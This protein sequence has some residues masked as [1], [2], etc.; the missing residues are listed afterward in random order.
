[1]ATPISPEKPIEKAQEATKAATTSAPR[2]RYRTLLFQ[3][4]LIAMTSAF[5]FLMVLA[6]STPFFPI[7]L[8][9]TR[10]IQLIS[11]P[12]FA[13]LMS[14]I[15]W[16]GYPPQSFIIPAFL[17]A[18]MW[19][20]GLRWEAVASL[21]AAISSS[22]IDVLVK[23][24]IRRP[25]PAADLVHVFRIL[26]SYSFPSGHVMFYVVFF[27][28]L[29]FL[30]FALLKPSPV[31]SVLLLFFAFMILTIGVSRIYLGQHWASDVL[32][33][34]LLGSLTLVANIAFYRWGKARFFVA[35][36]QP[37]NS[38]EAGA[39]HDSKQASR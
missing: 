9:I 12:A 36:T 15:S 18:L 39:R 10:G 29:F 21:V 32:G 4:T 16:P 28:F 6:K 13:T 2:R 11:N 5:A 19:G 25:R 7:D 37:V 20:L 14:I 17:V 27:G 26:N 23:D 38:E 30:A 8:Q 33:A 22:G 34:Y 35:R 3:G 31:R 24:Y 1:M